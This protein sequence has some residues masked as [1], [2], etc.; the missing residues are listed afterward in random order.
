MNFAG[1]TLRARASM[2][3]L[4]ALSAA[5]SAARAGGGSGDVDASADTDPSV[6]RS[7]PNDT[8]PSPD[9]IASPDVVAS[10]DVITSPDVPGV[11]CP[12]SIA[13][14][15]MPCAVVGDGC[16]GGGGP[17]SDSYACSCNPAHRWQCTTMPSACDSGVDVP[18]STCSLV[19]TYSVSLVA[20][21]N[22]YLSLRADGQWRFSPSIDGLP[23]STMGGT[24]TVSRTRVMVRE[25]T[26]S[27]T[28][29]TPTQTGTYDFS[30]AP[31][32]NTLTLATVAEPCSLRAMALAGQPLTRL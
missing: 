30:F 15:G 3:A 29:C 28:G 23:T 24:Y 27:L 16:G 19:G 26:T 11:P 8:P 6:D 7:A 22:I 9:V 4:V 20:L 17:C 31:G 5:C 18:A 25:T 2:I 12:S 14:N 32:C 21:G 10:P 1:L 13:G